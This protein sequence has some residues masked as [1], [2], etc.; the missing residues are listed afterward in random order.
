[1]EPDAPS[2]PPRTQKWGVH[3]EKWGPWS[4]CWP[5]LLSPPCQAAPVCYSWAQGCWRR[6]QMSGA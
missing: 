6:P 5:H 4:R 1:L 2:R 3:L